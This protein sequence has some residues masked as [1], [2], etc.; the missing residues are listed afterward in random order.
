M[1]KKLAELT[2]APEEMIRDSKS[3]KDIR[4]LR[5]TQ[6]AQAAQVEMLKEGSEIARNLGQAKGAQGKTA[7][8][9]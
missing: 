3:I 1:I 9:L 6:L 5:A 2:G 7:E 4:E 8:E